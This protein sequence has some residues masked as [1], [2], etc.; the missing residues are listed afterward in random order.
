MLLAT[1]FKKARQHDVTK[2]ICAPPHKNF[3]HHQNPKSAAA[4]HFP[5]VTMAMIVR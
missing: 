4:Q 1:S 3:A 2:S 5:I